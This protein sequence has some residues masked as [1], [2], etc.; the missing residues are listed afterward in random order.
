MR[1][2]GNAAPKFSV[3]VRQLYLTSP[4]PIGIIM[5]IGIVKKNG[6]MMVDVCSLKLRI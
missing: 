5:L 4:H 2:A 6:I 3:A 1:A